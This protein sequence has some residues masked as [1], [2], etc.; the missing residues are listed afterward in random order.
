VLDW[1]KEDVEGKPWA[2]LKYYPGTGPCHVNV[3]LAK[4]TNGDAVDDVT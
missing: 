1:V 3:S 2:E 4:L